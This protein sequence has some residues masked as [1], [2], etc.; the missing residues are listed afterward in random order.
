[1]WGWGVFFHAKKYTGI[2]NVDPPPLPLYLKHEIQAS[3]EETKFVIQP[4][5]IGVKYSIIAWVKVVSNRDICFIKAVLF[6]C[7]RGTFH[8]ILRCG[9]MAYLGPSPNTIR[10]KRIVHECVPQDVQLKEDYT[11]E[12]H[13]ALEEARGGAI[14]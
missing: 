14:P 3:S 1:M 4:K 2:Q 8:F 9:R 11:K 12:Y 10:V 13:I 5:S 6:L 7:E